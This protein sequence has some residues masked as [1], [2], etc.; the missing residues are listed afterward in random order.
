MAKPSLCIKKNFK[1]VKLIF[2]KG[3]TILAIFLKGVFG[4]GKVL[5]QNKLRGNTLGQIY[6]LW[7]C[8][9]TSRAVLLFLSFATNHNHLQGISVCVFDLVKYCAIPQVK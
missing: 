4:T 7:L 5:A 1:A 9:T 3:Y 8:L 6:P 2:T